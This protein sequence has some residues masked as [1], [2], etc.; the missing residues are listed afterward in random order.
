MNFEHFLSY[1]LANKHKLKNFKY[2]KKLLQ[3]HYSVLKLN[4]QKLKLGAIAF[5]IN[6]FNPKKPF[7]ELITIKFV[8]Q[9]T[10]NSDEERLKRFNDELG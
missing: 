7:E 10:S 4:R 9:D 2:A 3:Y 1:I 8:N 5:I 6:E